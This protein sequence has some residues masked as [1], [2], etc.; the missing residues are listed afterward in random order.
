MNRSTKNESSNLSQFHVQAIRV[1]LGNYKKI[2][3]ELLREAAADA[4]AQA[5]ALA[6]LNAKVSGVL[7]VASMTSPE[8]SMMASPRIPHSM[9]RI[10]SPRPILLRSSVRVIHTL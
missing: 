4:S 7:H 2:R 10:S 8:P 9:R 6:P 3:D 1:S 5:N